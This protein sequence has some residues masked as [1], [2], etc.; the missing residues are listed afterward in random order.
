[1]N[2]SLLYSVSVSHVKEQHDYKR[3][4]WDTDELRSL[5]AQRQSTVGTACAQI[6]KIIWRNTESELRNWRTAQATARLA[7]FKRLGDLGRIHMCPITGKYSRTPNFKKCGEFLQ[8]VYS[9]DRHGPTPPSDVDTHALC[10]HQIPRFPAEEIMRDLQHTAK[11]KSGD[12]SG[13]TLDMYLHGGHLFCE[14][15]AKI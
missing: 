7:E 14:Q 9:S 10:L 5:R 3:K 1:M 12:K 6:W 4:P 11:N 13:L 2:V 15:L 8:Q